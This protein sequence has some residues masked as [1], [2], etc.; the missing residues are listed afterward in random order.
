[1]ADKNKLTK[2]EIEKIKKLNAAKLKAKN[3]NNQ[4]LK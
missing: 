3:N 1:M 2:K 4:I